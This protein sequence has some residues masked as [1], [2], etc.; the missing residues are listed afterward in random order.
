MAMALAVLSVV[1]NSTPA[2]PQNTTSNTLYLLEILE[3]CEHAMKLGENIRF[4]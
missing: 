3:L 2:A 1:G 4:Q